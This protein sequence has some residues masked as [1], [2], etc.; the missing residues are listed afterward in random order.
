[1]HKRTDDVLNFARNSGSP[2]NA[3]RVATLVALGT[4]ANGQSAAYTTWK[5]LRNLA[6]HYGDLAKQRTLLMLASEQVE[7][8]I[9]QLFGTFTSALAQ[10]TL[11]AAGELP[12]LLAFASTLIAETT[13]YLPR[14]LAA[15]FDDL[16]CNINT[17]RQAGLTITSPSNAALLVQ[18]VPPQAGQS[19]LD[20]CCGLGSI[21]TR[22]GAVAPGLHLYGQDVNT[23]SNAFAR[24]RMFF[25]GYD[26]DIRTGDSLRAPAKWEGKATFDIVLCDPPSGPLAASSTEDPIISRFPGAP[27]RYE[28]LFIEHCLDQVAPGGR[29]A[30]MLPY[31]F[32]FRKGRD[33]AYRE[34]LIAEGLIEGVIAL[35]S[36]FNATYEPSS[37]V[38]VFRGTAQPGQDIRLLDARNLEEQEFE[39]HAQSRS[40]EPSVIADIYSGVL[41]SSSVISVNPNIIFRSDF[42][43]RPDN[44]LNRS[45]PPRPGIENLH[46]EAVHAERQAT[47]L[48]TSLDST[49]SELQLSSDP[50][51]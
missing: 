35:P 25:F 33:I 39:S 43:L 38:L 32:L 41:T 4:L 19:V 23:L 20:P 13:T 48:L 51:A 15:W 42:D 50:R 49:L 34:R 30:V 10:D 5:D 22:V 11:Q 29:A 24:L 1:M 21:L 14:D 46:R 40:L 16:I 27:V 37:A 3:R 9:P 45:I 44:F 36:G 2:D 31:G 8:S 47:E 6:V 12:S 18:L 17:G 28:T 7:L 26:F